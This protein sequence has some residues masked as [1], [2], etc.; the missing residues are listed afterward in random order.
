MRYEPKRM[1]PF[2]ATLIIVS[3]A[4]VYIISK[5]LNTLCSALY[6]LAGEIIP[7]TLSAYA[8]GVHSMPGKTRPKSCCDKT[9]FMMFLAAVRSG[10]RRHCEPAIWRVTTRARQSAF[11]PKTR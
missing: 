4:C 7:S 3:H 9:R 10:G 1:I 11:S 5:T 2:A 8:P 6:L